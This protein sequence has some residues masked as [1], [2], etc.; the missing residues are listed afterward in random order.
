VSNSPNVPGFEHDPVKLG[1]LVRRRF[2]GVPIRLEND[3]RVAV[4]GEHKRGAGRPFRDVLGVFV[5]TG[6]GGGLILEGKL[7][8]GGGGAGE[9]G[10]TAVNE[11]GRVCSCGQKGHLEAY[12]GR[13]RIEHE[14]RRRM[15]KG[16]PTILFD[17]MKKKGR[18]RVSSG[19]ISEALKHK[20]RMTKSLVADAAWALGV[21]LA[22][23]QN[24]L[25]ME[26]IIVGGGL[27]DR[28]GQ[29]FVDRVT[30]E[31]HPRLL[32]P[33]RAPAIITTELG[34]LSGAVGAALIATT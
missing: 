4:L 2:R 31:A 8:R 19:V 16:H 14:A 22:S 21:A 1:S 24:L 20:D 9:I 15:K 30:A 5:G 11:G 32:V 17:L 7:R 33:E 3:V 34:D 13:G 10:H 29:P 26:A 25:E 12:A 27:G 18:T 23:A 28:L 6:V